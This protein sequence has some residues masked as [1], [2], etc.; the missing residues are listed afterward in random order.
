MA[1]NREKYSGKGI[2]TVSGSNVI[3][4]FSGTNMVLNVEGS[5]TATLSGHGT[6]NKGTRSGQLTV[7][8][9]SVTGLG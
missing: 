9:I 1:G 5:G 4:K 8:G 6:W 3:V 2:I 7:E